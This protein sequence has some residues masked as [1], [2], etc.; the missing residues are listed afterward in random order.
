MSLKGCLGLG[1]FALDGDVVLGDQFAGFGFGERVKGVVGE[2]KPEDLRAVGSGG[3]GEEASGFAWGEAGDP[4]GGGA[5]GAPHFDGDGDGD[6]ALIG[7]THLITDD[8]AVVSCSE[9][10]LAGIA[11]LHDGA[12]EKLSGWGADA[13]LDLQASEDLDTDGGKFGI[14][15]L[16]FHTSHGQLGVGPL[17]HC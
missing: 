3:R 16:R 9:G 6:L 12:G 14:V 1:S 10:E 8:G 17:L 15:G 2:G 7:G 4:F 11:G 13:G 5:A